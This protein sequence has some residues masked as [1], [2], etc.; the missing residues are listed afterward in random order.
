VIELIDLP[1]GARGDYAT[2]LMPPLA[3]GEML[4]AWGSGYARLVLERAQG[5]HIIGDGRY[6]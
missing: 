6:V 5:N 1:P 3:R 4:R 2:A